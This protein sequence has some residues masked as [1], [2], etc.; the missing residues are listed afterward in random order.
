LIYQSISDDVVN[1][2]TLFVS[3]AVGLPGNRDDEHEPV[4]AESVNDVSL[5]KKIMKCK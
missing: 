5:Q 2:S 3:L 4:R 1:L